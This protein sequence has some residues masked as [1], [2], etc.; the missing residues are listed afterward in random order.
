M[1]GLVETQ[2]PTNRH[3]SRHPTI[4]QPE[5]KQ[6]SESDGRRTQTNLR[7]SP[8]VI[9]EDQVLEEEETQTTLETKVQEDRSTR[10]IDDW[11]EPYEKQ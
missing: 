3:N 8:A 11:P 10:T 4:W 6:R 9:Q 7:C 2:R 1:T 5:Q